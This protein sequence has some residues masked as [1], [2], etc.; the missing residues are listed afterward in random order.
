[1][2]TNVEISN[3]QFKY[4]VALFL[5][6]TLLYLTYF[7][8]KGGRD[9]YILF[10]VAAVGSLLIALLNSSFTKIYPGADITDI[11]TTVFGRILGKI[12]G[13]IYFIFFM[14]LCAFNLR[15]TG[16]FVATNLLSGHSWVLIV[17]IF[18]VVCLYAAGNGP[19]FFSY[20]GVIGCVAL[21]FMSAILLLCVLPHMEVDHFLPVMVQDYSTYTDSIIFMLAIP[22][23]EIFLLLMFS[24]CIK[25][26]IKAGSYIKGIAIASVF[27]ITSLIRIIAVFGPIVKSFSYPSFE[28]T[29]IINLSSS[30]SRVESIF[31]PFILFALFMRV[32]IMIYCISRLGVRIV[33]EKRR[34]AGF[35]P[36]IV[37]ALLV[38]LTVKI[39][40]SNEEL[41]EIMLDSFGYVAFAMLIVVPVVIYIVG[42]VKND[43]VTSF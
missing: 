15:Q 10:A 34:A 41:L 29:H 2:E 4:I 1:M 11:F 32:A 19:E 8:Q 9:T 24:P 7:L 43:R 38:V 26:G 31:S 12:L 25:G 28:L 3:K 39:A 35:V 40:G 42:R 27:I 22:F 20:T 5:Q 14:Y 33:G 21:L 18:V 13:C 6:G 23:S 17:V 37:S 16:Q 36:Y 30:L